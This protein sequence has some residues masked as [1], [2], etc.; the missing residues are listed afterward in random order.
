MQVLFDTL[1]DNSRI[2][3]YVVVIAFVISGGFMGY[4]AYL[5]NSSGGQAPQQS[6]SVIAKVNDMKIYREEYLL[7]LQQHAPQSNLNSSQIIPF[8]Y[9]ILNLLIE[10][11]LVLS[12]ADELNIEPE[13]SES[14]ID[15]IYQNILKQNKMDEMSEQEITENLAENNM[16]I[17]KLR[18]DIRSDLKNNKMISQTINSAIAEISVSEKEISNLY[19]QRYPKKDKVENEAADESQKKPSFEEV[20]ED[21]A[22][23][24]KNN[25]RNQA[26]ND[27]I[28]ELKDSA[29]IVINDSVLN[30]Y[31][32]LKNENYSQAIDE[33]SKL[34]DQENTNPIYAS[35][36]ADAYLGKN[37]TAKAEETYSTAIENNPKNIELKFSYT[38]FLIEQENNEAALSQLD[39]ISSLAEDDYMTHYR[40]FMMYSQLGAEEKAQESMKKIQS[41]SQKMQQKSAESLKQNQE[42]LKEETKEITEETEVDNNINKEN[43]K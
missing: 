40:L 15:E 24:I 42:E 26:A 31:H 36:L 19:Q 28:K 30:A 34:V 2:I 41:I 3:V 39:D 8:K 22:Q 38:R 37:N 35:Y 23:E 21:L 7:L 12:K 5:S 29:E 14:E 4:G 16:T 32:E 33:F 18:D 1:R 6:S 13:V 9:D 43:N 25:K 10:R 11:K 27:W 17:E 20:K